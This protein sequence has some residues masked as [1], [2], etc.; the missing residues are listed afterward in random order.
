MCGGGRPSTPKGPV[1]PRRR[2]AGY[3]SIAQEIGIQPKKKGKLS[4][5]Q[6]FSVEQEMQR[7]RDAKIQAQFEEQK[8]IA[9][10]PPPPAP[11]RVATAAASAIELPPTAAGMTNVAG[12]S[13]VEMAI[14]IR[15]GV[16][17]RKLRTDIPGVAGGAGGLGIPAV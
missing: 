17:R 8:A 9:T 12:G 16:G 5:Q 2:D 15:A 13:A 1:D 11:E 10:A 6:V 7:R 14:P 4:D 3:L